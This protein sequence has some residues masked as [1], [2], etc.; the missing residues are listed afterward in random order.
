MCGGAGRRMVCGV[1]YR[2][3]LSIYHPPRTLWQGKEALVTEAT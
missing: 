2:S 3:L 1:R